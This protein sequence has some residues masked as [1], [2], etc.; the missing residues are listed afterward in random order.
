MEAGTSARVCDD[1][2]TDDGG[3]T[4]RCYTPIVPTVHPRIPVT[5]DPELARALA[6]VEHYF[7]DAPTAR[8]VRELALRGAEAIEQ[9]Q[10]ERGDA[11]ERLIVLFTEPNDRID[12]DVLEHI[13]ELAWRR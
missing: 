4:P 9:E 11:I 1:F 10:N 6:R 7:P 12:L 13:D 5:N 2:S 8:I 3:A